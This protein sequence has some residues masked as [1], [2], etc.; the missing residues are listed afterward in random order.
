MKTRT[1]KQTSSSALMV[2]AALTRPVF[3]RLRRDSTSDE[4]LGLA[5]HIRAKPSFGELKLMQFD[6]PEHTICTEE[7]TFV[8][9]RVVSESATA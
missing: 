3:D 6:L 7:S 2:M 4:L 8:A 9:M 5:R 1:L